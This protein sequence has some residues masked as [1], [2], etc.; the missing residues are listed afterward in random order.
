MKMDEALLN[1]YGKSTAAR[2]DKASLIERGC[3]LTGKLPVAS[4]FRFSANP[5]AYSAI[6]KTLAA[7]N[8]RKYVGP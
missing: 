1:H 6:L 8:L 7:E 3:A 5:R 2:V 4:R